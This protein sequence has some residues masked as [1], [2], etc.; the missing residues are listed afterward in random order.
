MTISQLPHRPATAVQ[1]APAAAV[2]VMA[3][4]GSGADRLRSAMSAFPGLT[5]TGGTGILPLCHTAVTTWQTVDG[6]DDQRFSSLGAASARTLITGLVTAILAR[7]GGSRWCEFTT[8]P[9]AA[10]QTFAR[11]YPQTQ[12][13]IVH[14]RA[15]IMVRAIL[16]ASRWGLADPEFAPF[17][18]AHPASS[19]AAL[20][21]YWVTHTIA[22]LDFEQA[23]LQS[24]LRVRIEDLIT[25]SAQTLREISD[26]LS[27]G[28][29]A[30]SPW[31][32]QE[33]HGNQPAD[34]DFPATG[35]PLS[36][37]P[38]PLL[39]QLSDLHDKLGYPPVPNV[40]A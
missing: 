30:A 8:A 38:A 3:Y 6:R 36:L 25:N 7:N 9:H 11:L 20:A 15:D 18:A 5:C 34:G 2:I 16:G 31:H 17:V 29:A 35:L 27:L 23:H 37:I 26:F 1:S 32:L 19:L 40:E 39:A 24:C 28:G 4:T 10:G 14:R 12:F 33:S 21:S 22:Q 13:L